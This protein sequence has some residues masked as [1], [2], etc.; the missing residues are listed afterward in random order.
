MIV[1]FYSTR[2]PVTGNFHPLT[3]WQA[4][5]TLFCSW[6][7]L[8]MWLWTSI[9][10]SVIRHPVTHREVVIQMTEHGM[11]L[12]GFISDIEFTRRHF[13]IQNG[14]NESLNRSSVGCHYWR[15]ESPSGLTGRQPYTG[16]ILCQNILQSQILYLP[17]VFHKYCDIATCFVSL[18]LGY[19]R[20]IFS[21]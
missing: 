8:P 6:I 10:Y 17:D 20:F 1:L 15:H 19:G 16:V 21:M 11:G 14:S 12:F 3:Q 5:N 13:L 2:R 7:V 9:G 4:M 18:L